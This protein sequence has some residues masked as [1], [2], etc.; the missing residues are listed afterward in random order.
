MK[1]FLVHTGKR[2]FYASLLQQE[3]GDQ[4]RKGRFLLVRWL[5]EHVLD[6]AP[7]F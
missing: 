7:V 2:Y 4:T 6:P 3:G 5:L 1:R